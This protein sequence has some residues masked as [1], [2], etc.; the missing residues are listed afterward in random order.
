MIDKVY[1]PYVQPLETEIEWRA[2]AMPEDKQNNLDSLQLHRL[3]LGHSFSER[4]F[5]EAYLIGERYEGEGFD[6]ESMELEVKRQLTEQGEYAADWGL[7]FELEKE[8]SV[9][10]WEAATALIA[11]RESGRWVGTANLFA[12][13]EWGDDI[14]NEFETQLRLQGRYRFAEAFEPALELYAGQDT[15]GIGPMAS[16]VQRLT[17]ARQLYWEFGLIF[18]I[19]DESPDQSFRL[20][21]EYEFY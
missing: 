2:L 10:K 14:D 15:V 12:I 18:G 11:A 6:I 5:G 9:N 13:Y 16:G 3:G 20:L 7:L 4:W 17:G 8:L 21:L 1:N 19:T